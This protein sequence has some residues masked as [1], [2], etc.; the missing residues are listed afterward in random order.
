MV[1]KMCSI[2]REKKEVK[3]S[4]KGSNGH[5]TVGKREMENITIGKGGGGGWCS[6][7]GHMTVGKEGGPVGGEGLF[8]LGPWTEPWALKIS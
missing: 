8:C 3:K 7:N 2:Y 1:N 5:M 4:G 6:T